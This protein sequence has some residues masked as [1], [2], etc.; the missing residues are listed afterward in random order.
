M[1][2]QKLPASKNLKAAPTPDE[3]RLRQLNRRQPVLQVI[4]S[5]QL[6]FAV[7][8]MVH[9][10][11]SRRKMGRFVNGWIITIVAVL[12]ALI[13]AGL[14]AYLV[15]ESSITNEFGAAVGGA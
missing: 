6:T 10:T 12:V 2:L 3:M 5:L 14:N 7:V 9:F 11:C 13:I 8:P 1:M 15:V 4:L